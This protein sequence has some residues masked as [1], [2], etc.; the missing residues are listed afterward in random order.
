MAGRLVASN[1]TLT[2]PEDADIII[3]NTCSFIHDAREE[4]MEMILSACELKKQGDCQAVLVA[5]CLPQRY[6]KRIQEALP[7]VDAFIGID[8]LDDIPAIVS[9]LQKGKH[10]II[11][12]TENAH[13]LFDPDVPVVFSSGANAYLKIAEGCN[14]R[15][16]FCAIP[17]IRGRHRSRT[18][19]KIYTEAE[20]LIK[21]GFRE[22]DIISQDITYY[23]EDL[24]DGTNLA[25]LLRR[26]GEID[27]KFRMRL[28][29]GYPGGVTD[30]LLEVMAV[31]PQ[32]CN[33]LDIP[34]QHSHPDV[35]TA[36]QRK[37][38]IKPVSDMVTRIRKALP[39]AAVRTTCL[40]G[41]P[42]ET[43]AHFQHLLHFCQEM[44]FDHL[45]AFVYSPEEDTA[46]Y[47]MENVPSL[48]EAQ[49]RHNRLME[50]Q[51][52]ISAEI[53][54]S[55]IGSTV[56]IL[57]ENKISENQWQGRTY[58]QAP[59]VDGI[60]TINN[61]PESAEKGTFIKAKITAADTY[62]LTAEHIPRG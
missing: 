28:L 11:S 27:D 24:K 52:Q 18:I 55:L 59:E 37:S 49:D 33:Y 6:R 30:E 5:G 21:Q 54:R 38:T 22:L 32:V 51:Q 48:E 7:D 45:G 43:E 3:V 9:D 29:Y 42:G 40:V 47:D 16:A 41:F 44:R 46:A 57:L 15:C 35:L 25:S 39:D 2:Q 4:S 34:I 31:T 19:D 14:H 1:I 61:I 23:G 12:V 17:G 60:T 58:R 36:M 62:D 8:Q 13:R 53:N 10:D 50:Q 20:S 56:E 26:L